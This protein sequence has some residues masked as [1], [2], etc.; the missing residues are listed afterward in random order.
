[1]E[2]TAYLL[3]WYV[4]KDVEHISKLRVS[5]QMWLLQ[6]NFICH[7][8]LNIIMIPH[9]HPPPIF[10]LAST[11]KL[12]IAVGFVKSINDKTNNDND[13]SYDSDYSDIDND[14]A[15]PVCQSNCNCCTSACTFQ[16][17]WRRYFLSGDSTSAHH[18]PRST[19]SIL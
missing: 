12:M 7:I 6:V 15:I 11:A 1:M 3:T 5:I 2:V 13:D 16:L 8:A 17:S 14:V 18:C 19:L 10:L 9:H 4:A